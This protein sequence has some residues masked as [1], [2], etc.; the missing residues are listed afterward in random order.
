MNIH[1]ASPSV[2]ARQ[3]TSFHLSN[4]ERDGVMMHLLQMSDR[5]RLLHG[6]IKRAAEFFAISPRTISLIWSHGTESLENGMQCAD[7]FPRR[8]GATGRRVHDIRAL[9]QKIKSVPLHRRNDFRSLANAV[10]VPRTTL[11]RVLKTGRLKRHSSFVRPALRDEDKLHRVAFCLSFVWPDSNSKIFNQMHDRVHVDEK[12][13]NPKEITEKYYLVEGEEDIF[14]GSCSFARLRV[15][16]GTSSVASGLMTLQY[17]KASRSI[18][19]LISNVVAAF[20]E[21]PADTLDDTFITLQTVM[22]AC[23]LA[24]GGNQF[25]TPH[26]NKDKLRRDGVGIVV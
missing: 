13:F 24:G 6:D 12:W 9:L 23:L 25:K 17:K 22:E 8:K 15:L 1:S 20:E 14:R 21:L 19:E 2:E 7:V 5:G 26:I 4:G 11:Q 3:R 16:A 18:D 10:G